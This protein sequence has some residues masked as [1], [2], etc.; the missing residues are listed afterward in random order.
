[1]VIVLPSLRA[2]ILRVS[3]FAP[4]APVRTPAAFVLRPRCSMAVVPR[5]DVPCLE[6]IRIPSVAAGRS[7]RQRRK[8]LAEDEDQIVHAMAFIVFFAGDD[9][10]PLAMTGKCIGQTVILAVAGAAIPQCLVADLAKDVVGAVP[11]PEIH[12][13]EASELELL[14]IPDQRHEALLLPTNGRSTRPLRRQRTASFATVAAP[15]AQGI[16]QASLC[17]CFPARRNRREF[18]NAP[19]LLTRHDF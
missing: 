6:L 16:R 11:H 5:R 8:V 7:H 12:T 14:A 19:R 9:L 4:S 13:L 17:A 1:M 10:N 15:W 3:W 18:F 2:I